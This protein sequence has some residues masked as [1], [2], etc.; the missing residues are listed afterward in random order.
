MAVYFDSN[1]A[2]DE[3]TRRSITGVIGFIGN[4]PVTWLS[5]RQ[6]AI[7]TSTYL[8]ELCAAKIGTEEAITLHYMLRS[9]GVPV[10]GSTLLIGDNLGSL[11]STSSPTSP[12]KKK[13]SQIAYHYVREC[14]AAGIIS[15]RKINT[16]YNYADVGTKALG[17]KSFWE[18][19]RRLF[20]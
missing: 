2:H 12:C 10:K 6:G 1:W 7:A 18:H 15:V 16:E 19:F 5:K 14:N 13:H 8:A 4:T 17:K 11:I 20:G 9:L 3:V